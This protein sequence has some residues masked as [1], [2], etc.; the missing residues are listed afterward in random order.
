MKTVP[1][2]MTAMLCGN[3]KIFQTGAIKAKNNT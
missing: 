1:A 2:G 3:I